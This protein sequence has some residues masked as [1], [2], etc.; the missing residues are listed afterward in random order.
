MTTPAWKRSPRGDAEYRVRGGVRL[1]WSCDWLGSTR[2]GPDRDTAGQ[3]V[4]HHSP[5][6][7]RQDRAFC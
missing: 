3:F 5:M 2:V 7:R 6:K 4:R 1:S